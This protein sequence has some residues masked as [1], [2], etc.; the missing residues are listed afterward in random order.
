MEK[1]LNK[2]VISTV[3]QKV[4]AFFCLRANIKLH[5][6]EIARQLGISPSAT[7]EALKFLSNEDVLNTERIGKMVFYTL[8]ENCSLVRQYK[9]MTIIFSLEPLVLELKHVTELVI[10]FGS[11]VKG[12]NIE[13]SDIDLFIA[14][15]NPEKTEEILYQFGK[16]FPLEIRPVII[17]LNEWMD[18]EEKNSVFYNEV[19]KGILLYRKISYG[20]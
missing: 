12:E 4:L 10:I 9:T 20:R 5:E 8:N 17:S 3:I 2:I 19:R 14:T 6:R 13:D 1:M 15:S 7:H 16:N 18:Y 11:V